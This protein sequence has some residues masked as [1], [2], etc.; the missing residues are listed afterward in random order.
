M[1]FRTKDQWARRLCLAG[2][3]GVGGSRLAQIDLL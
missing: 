2:P 1:A 3:A